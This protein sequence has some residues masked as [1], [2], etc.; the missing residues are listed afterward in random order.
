MWH[1]WESS[2]RLHRSLWLHRPRATCLPCRLLQKHHRHSTEYLQGQLINFIRC[3]INNLYSLNRRLVGA[4]CYRGRIV[5]HSWIFCVDH[6]SYPKRGNLYQRK[7]MK[8]AKR[9]RSVLTVALPMVSWGVST[10]TC[11]YSDYLQYNYARC[12]RAFQP[13]THS[14]QGFSAN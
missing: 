9:Y 14:S 2:G 3:N 11:T 7:S 13:T 10:R 1:L 8:S 6:L 12:C 5:R 4:F